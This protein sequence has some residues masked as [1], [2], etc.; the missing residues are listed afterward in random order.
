MYYLSLTYML[1][2][3]MSVPAVYSSG[4]SFLDTK[5]TGLP[6]GTFISYE[7]MLWMRNNCR[8]VHDNAEALLLLQVLYILIS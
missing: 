8:Y 2:M 4:L 1:M 6:S 5:T 3:L 7:A